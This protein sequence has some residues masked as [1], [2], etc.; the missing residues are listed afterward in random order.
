MADKHKE[1]DEYQLGRYYWM[2]R[3]RE[4]SEIKKSEVKDKLEKALVHFGQAIM[5]DDKFAQAHSGIADVNLILPYYTDD[6]NI[7]EHKEKAS[8]AINLAIVRE[9]E[10]TQKF[11]EVHTSLGHLKE[12]DGSNYYEAEEEYIN[13]TELNKK[14]APAYYRYSNLLFNYFGKIKESI[15]NAEKAVKY[16]PHSPFYLVALGNMFTFSGDYGAAI[17]KYKEAIK[18]DPSTADAWF[19]LMIT[20]I[21]DN[22]F[23]Q[24]REAIRRWAELAGLDV[25]LALRFISLVEKPEKP[26]KELIDIFQDNGWLIYLYA[27]LGDGKKTIKLLKNSDESLGYLMYFPAYDFIRKDPEFEKLIQQRKTAL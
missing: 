16:E 17:K 15:D 2:E 5:F 6:P 24:A 12:F 13:A 27:Y 19:W 25:D 3:R 9:T 23:G 22:N 10:L 18:L 20:Y 1:I 4:F 8:D 7:D 21:S 26:Q 14:Y 11:A